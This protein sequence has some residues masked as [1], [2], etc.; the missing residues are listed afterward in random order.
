MVRIHYDERSDSLAI[1]INEGLSAGD[2]EIIPGVTAVWDDDGDLLAL[3][4]FGVMQ[5]F[6][7]EGPKSINFAVNFENPHPPGVRRRRRKK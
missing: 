7:G 1:N 3:Y 2:D 6:K 5:R 4:V